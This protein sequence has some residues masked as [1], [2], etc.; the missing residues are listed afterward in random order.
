MAPKTSAQKSTR[1][2][3]IEALATHGPLT[4]SELIEPDRSG[5]RVGISGQNQ[6]KQK[7]RPGQ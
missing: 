1:Y 6:A 7:P 4:Q 5:V 2:L 3:I